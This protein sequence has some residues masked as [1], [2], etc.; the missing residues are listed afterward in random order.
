MEQF[1]QKTNRKPAESCKKTTKA[2]RKIP[3]N[4][5]GHPQFQLSKCSSPAR[6]MPYLYAGCRTAG[7]W[8]KTE[9]RD[10][11]VTWE[12]IQ[13]GPWQPFCHSLKQHH[14]SR[15]ASWQWHSCFSSCNC[16]AAVSSHARANAQARLTFCHNLVLDLGQPQQGRRRDFGLRVRVEV[17]THTQKAHWTSVSTQAPHAS[18]LG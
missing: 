5:Y 2:A 12:V 6:S 14:G 7:S 18:T 13:V 1:S 4:T 8:E 15:P 16:S 10:A 11:E 3:P 9:S 17:Q